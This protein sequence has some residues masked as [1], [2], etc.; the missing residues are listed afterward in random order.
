LSSSGKPPW[1]AWVMHLTPH[2][3]IPQKFCCTFLISHTKSHILTVCSNFN[4]MNFDHLIRWY[5]VGFSI[6]NYFSISTQSVYL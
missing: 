1:F 4:T 3:V 2:K 5:L 6:V